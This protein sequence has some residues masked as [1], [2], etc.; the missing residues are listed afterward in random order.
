MC[1]YIKTIWFNVPFNAV[2]DFLSGWSLHWYNQGAEV[3]YYYCVIS[4]SPFMSVNI[5]F[6]YLGAPNLV[7]FK[8][9]NF[10]EEF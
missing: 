3:P 5:C 6:T 9:L 8:K 4:I 1:I 7:F 10:L 2:T